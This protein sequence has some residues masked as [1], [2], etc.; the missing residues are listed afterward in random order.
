MSTYYHVIA[1][2]EMRSH[3]GEE[4]DRSISFLIKSLKNE[5]PIQA[6]VWT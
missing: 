5:M 4:L 6:V 1:Y 2:P 3:F